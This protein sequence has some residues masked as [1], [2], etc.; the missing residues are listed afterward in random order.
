MSC[1]VAQV[2]H[3]ST[4][5]IQRRRNLLL[6]LCRLFIIAEKPPQLINGTPR[7]FRLCEYIGKRGTNNADVVAKFPEFHSVRNRKSRATTGQQRGCSGCMAGPAAESAMRNESHGRARRTER[8][9]DEVPDALNVPS[10][11][12]LVPG[13]GRSSLS[14]NS[15]VAVSTRSHVR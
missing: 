15:A 8:P 12:H 10:I 1:T 5:A 4:Y 11:A 3:R 13:V 2:A 7:C 6:R 9:I 14:K